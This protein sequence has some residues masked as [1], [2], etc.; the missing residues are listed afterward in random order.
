M[1]RRTWL[2]YLSVCRTCEHERSRVPPHHAVVHSPLLPPDH[3]LDL[4]CSSVPTPSVPSSNGVA[5]TH[6]KPAPGVCL[7]ACGTRVLPPPQRGTRPPLPPTLHGLDPHCRVVLLRR[8]LR[9]SHIARLA[10]SQVPT[11][12]RTDRCG[13]GTPLRARSPC[14]A[15]SLRTLD[16]DGGVLATLRGK[17]GT[18]C[19]L[20]FTGT[21][22]QQLA[23]PSARQVHADHALDC[24]RRAVVSASTDVASYPR[25]VSPPRLRL[26]GGSSCVAQREPRSVPHQSAV[27]SPPR[28]VAS[29]LRSRCTKA[30]Q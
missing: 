29:V 9:R 4:D 25:G 30:T 2:S 14:A 1:R 27:P 7:Y 18:P 20:P 3:G 12:C 26:N 17:R 15:L 16:G 13:A 24:R 11:P 28:C 10:P 22:L 6:G 8:N 23:P 21:C 19:L 5:P